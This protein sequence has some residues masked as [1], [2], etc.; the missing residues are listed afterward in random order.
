M[1]GGAQLNELNR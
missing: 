1:F